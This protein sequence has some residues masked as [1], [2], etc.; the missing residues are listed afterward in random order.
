MAQTVEKART[1]TKQSATH[2]LEPLTPD[3]IKAASAIVRSAHSDLALRFSTIVLQEP[4]KDVVYGFK[5]GRPVSRSAAVVAL[6]ESTGTTWVGSVLL[7]DA[8]LVAWTKVE[9]GQAS[10]A[11]EDFFA[12]IGAVKQDRRWQEAMRKRGITDFDKVQVDPWIP[13]SFG[14]EVEQ[15]RRLTRC[16]SY[17]REEPTDQGYA[18]PIEGVLAFVDPVRKEVV[19]VHDYGVAPIPP[20]KGNLDPESNAPLRTDLKPVSITQPEGPSFSVDGN[21]VRWQKWSFRVSQHPIEGLVLHTVGYEDGG[22]VRPILYRAALSE[23]VVPY[24]TIAPMHF[25]KN[26]FDAGEIGLGKCVNALELGCDCLG[27]IYY[28]DSYFTDGA[29]E[30]EHRPNSICMHEEDYGVLWKHYDVF[31]D[32]SEVR[33]SRRLV[34][35]SF[36]T[37]GNYDYGFFWYFYLDGTIQLEIKL[38]GFMQTMAVADGDAPGAQ[39]VAPNLAAP[40]HQHLFN[41]RLDFDVDGRDNTVYE[42]DV[43]P[44]A[45]GDDNPHSNLF[46]PR[47]TAL[48]SE[49]EAQRVVDPFKSR[50]WRVVNKSSKNR[51]GQEVGYRVMPNSTPTLFAGEKSAVRKRAAF[52]TKNLWVTPYSAAEMH[53]A[54]DFPNQHPGGAGLADWTRADRPLEDTDVVLWYTFGLSHIARAEDWPIVPVEYTGFMLQPV[55]FFDR[56]PAMDVPPPIANGHCHDE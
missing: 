9:Q 13:G 56:N 16:V 50:T 10:L 26:A 6:D 48:R 7:D 51:L 49:K 17:L 20:E 22:K 40:H 3:E 5:P 8:K 25:W 45:E 28:F 23:M 47:L 18:K 11:R 31:S 19:E 43:E 1:T 24:G 38:T 41:Y 42:V 29:G 36:H 44:V 34:V 30:P 33:R 4:E 14:L 21:E 39:V 2:P 12:A 46:E 32:R 52:A 53:A 15:G 27:E 37:V 35:S 55:N 54:G